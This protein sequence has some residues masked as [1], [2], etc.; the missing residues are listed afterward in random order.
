MR[1]PTPRS[2]EQLRSAPT[3]TEE[4]LNK[5]AEL[6]YGDH[7]TVCDILDRMP[8]TEGELRAALLN[9]FRR[10]AALEKQVAALDAKPAAA[11][12]EMA[13]HAA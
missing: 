9:A 6:H 11:P 5:L 12:A 13:R 8:C 1:L 4:P 3:P 7:D 2:S 10:I